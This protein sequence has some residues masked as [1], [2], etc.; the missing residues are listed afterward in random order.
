ISFVSEGKWIASGLLVLFI[1]TPFK[2]A[3]SAYDDT[4]IATAALMILPAFLIISSKT[5]MIRLLAPMTFTAITLINSAQ[6]ASIWLSYRPEYEALKSS[7]TLLDR[8][9]FALVAQSEAP[10][11]PPDDWNGPLFR[12]APVLAVHYSDAFVPS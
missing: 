6:V 12:Y 2:A 8:G 10:L 4:R 5:R 11:Y 3:G 7:F 9:A 1:L